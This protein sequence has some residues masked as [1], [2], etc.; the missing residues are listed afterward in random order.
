MRVPCSRRSSGAVISVNPSQIE[1]HIVQAWKDSRH[2]KH[3]LQEGLALT[4]PEKKSCVFC[5][6]NLSPEAL[7]LLAVYENFFQ[8]GYEKLQSDVSD[9][10]RRFLSF[11]AE[12]VMRQ[13]QADLSD[14]GLASGIT[15]EQVKTIAQQKSTVDLEIERKSHNLQYQVNVDAIDNLEKSTEDFRETLQKLRESL[16]RGDDTKKLQEL[17]TK[18]SVLQLN[19]LRFSE[20]W[21]EFCKKLVAIEKEAKEVCAVRDS[22]R[23]ELQQFA[24]HVFALHKDAVNG[25]LE[26]LDADF[27]I[28]MTPLRK[29]VGKSERVFSLV[30]FD[31]FPV[32]I[33][34]ESASCHAFSNTLSDSD[35]RVLAF[36][37][38]LSLI[39]HD[40]DIDKKIVV[41]DDPISSLDDER[42]RKSI[43]LLADVG[44][45]E[46]IASGAQQ[47]K[48][49]RQ[50]LI[51]T[52]DR[53]FFASLHGVPPFD[54]GVKL[55]IESDGIH[56]GKKKSKLE[57]CDIQREFLEDD[58]FS[59]LRTLKEVRDGN[60]N[61]V[62]FE[63]FALKCR[64]VLEHIF[65]RKYYF[66]LEDEIQKRKSVRS[67]V[68]KLAEKRICGY[69]ETTKQQNFLRLC[70]DL[71]IEL[72]DTD[73]QRSDGDAR[74]I[75]R[76]FFDC[77]KAI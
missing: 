75:V 36:A 65:K 17:M 3:F 13:I 38:F 49:P 10:K 52:H 11:N 29:L 54:S 8:Q 1:E 69:E 26:K 2:T 48:R 63:K 32:D 27:R 64:T 4:K 18:L 35:K 14:H 72:H 51:M 68:E 47:K 60:Y 28:K 33:A 59:D 9:M 67:Y 39:A 71:H 6:Q 77:L 20:K 61:L 5:G 34:E 30:F 7:H 57:H 73:I 45:I 15:E 21:M 31:A 70:T 22:K 76:D 23:E 62:D 25:F 16:E 12:A 44:Y 55:K 56:V 24:D 43:H 40:K 37:F 19:A 50:R 58:L 66:E 53:G 74:S 42:K 46:T 41:F